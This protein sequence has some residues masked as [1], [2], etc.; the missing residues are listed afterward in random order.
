MPAYSVV[1]PTYNSCRTLEKL[2]KS[3]EGQEFTDFETIVIDD[4]SSDGT[5]S[6]VKDFQ[7]YYE[8]QDENRGPATARNRG[9]E[10]ATAEWI[11]F[12]DADTEFQPDTL[13]TIDEVLKNCDAD[14]LVGAY[15]GTPANSGFV[16]KYKALWEYATIDLGIPADERGLSR[17]HTWAPRPGIVRKSALESV[18][19]FDTRFRGADLEDMEFGYRLSQAGYA[20]Y[21]AHNVR[22]KHNYPASI[23]KELTPFARRAALWMRMMRSRRRFDATG[24][25]SSTQAVSHFCGFLAFWCLLGAV[26]YPRVLLGAF[27]VLMGVYFLLN[28]SFLRLAWRE[29]GLI[30]TLK[31][32][33]YCWLHTVVLGFA[34]AYGLVTPFRGEH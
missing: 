16:P 3:L 26:V 20:I 28:T 12:A 24:E 6:M 13:K 1:I 19:G 27:A 8:L 22:I 4:G 34:A 30:F 11:V 21:M 14:A 5:A 25:G 10:L 9:A 2:L 31:S 18:N 23:R 29:A 32:F 33:A 7:V 17:I 15:S